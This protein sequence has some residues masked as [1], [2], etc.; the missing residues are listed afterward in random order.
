LPPH[1]ELMADP[2]PSPWQ[3]AAPAPP[4]PNPWTPDAPPVNEWNSRD[5]MDM[6]S[7]EAINAAF[8]RKISL[9]E[10]IDLLNRLKIDK[11][12]HSELV[13]VIQMGSFFARNIL[14]WT[15]APDNLDYWLNAGSLADPTQIM[16]HELFMTLEPIVD[17]LCGEHYDA[18]VAGIN[19][20]L[21]APAGT[22]FPAEAVTFK[23]P[24]GTPVEVIPAESPL[25]AGGEETIYKESGTRTS[26][27]PDD[28][29]NAVGGVFL[30]PR[31]KVKS[32][33]VDT[34][35][36]QVTIINWEAWFWDTYDWNEGGKRGDPPRPR[37]QTGDRAVS[38]LHR[39]RAETWRNRPDGAAEAH[40]EGFTDDA[41]RGREDCAGRKDHAAEGLP[42]LQRQS[43][44]FRC[45][46]RVR[47]ADRYDDSAAM[48]ER[49]LPGR[50]GKHGQVIVHRA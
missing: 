33:V 45:E 42:D 34:G 3:P 35:D 47:Q 13:Q 43:V 48:S 28:M 41:D 40:S 39:G 26:A 15:L 6:I 22:K 5:L 44:A 49:T 31:V 11:L 27:I 16:K 23:G 8:G 20:R 38:V 21:S 30:V 17:T 4:E 7:A 10:L 24:L 12:S 25:R 32:E 36:W 18:I 9:W 1:G 29:Y 2:L 46:Q 14:N 50:S 19:S 37:Q